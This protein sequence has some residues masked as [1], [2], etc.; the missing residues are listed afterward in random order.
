MTTIECAACLDEV[1]AREATSIG[2]GDAVCRRCLAIEVKT[3]ADIGDPPL[4]IADW[5]IT[6]S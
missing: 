3:R 5:N 4:T 2:Y 1:P 6:F